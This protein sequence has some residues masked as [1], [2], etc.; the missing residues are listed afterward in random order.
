MHNS[1]R[2]DIKKAV[3]TSKKHLSIQP[4]ILLDSLGCLPE[5]KKAAP[6]QA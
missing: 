6:R 2:G 5:Y 3:I 1:L 4:L